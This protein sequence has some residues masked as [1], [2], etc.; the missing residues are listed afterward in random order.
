MRGKIVL[1]D[2]IGYCWGVRRTLEIIQ[3]AG[4]P[5]N[6]IA[7]IGDVIHNPQVV[8][9]LRR[10]GVQTALSVDDASRR[11]FSQIA[12]TAHG[13]S[14][15]RNRRAGELGLTT[16][17]TTCPLVTKV[18]RLAQKLVKQGYFVVVYGDECHPE[19]RGILG[20]AGTS[21]TVAAKHVED[22][23]WNAPRGRGQDQELQS[24]PRKVAVISQTTKIVEEFLKFTRDLTDLVARDGGEIRIC[25]TICAPTTERQNALERLASEVDVI[26]VVGGRKSS[27]TARLAEVG[28]SYG[29]ES[30]HIESELDIDLAW[31]TSAHNVGVTAGASTPDYVIERVID[32]LAILGY[33]R[34]T[35]NT[36]QEQ[37]DLEHEPSY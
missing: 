9:R 1:A 28:R 11:G 7:T 12:I 24:P 19:V 34:P 27:N 5:A 31:L 2:T 30:H 36:W 37:F 3:R 6:Q 35:M 32:Q 26:L 22:L 18:Q 21:R 10:S 15:E 16:V 25:N 13:A 4:H 20:W 17:D 29:V 23:P 33:D 14:P 8:E